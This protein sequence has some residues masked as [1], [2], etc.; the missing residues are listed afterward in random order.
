MKVFLTGATG[1]VGYH[2]AC[3]LAA[4]G[5]QLRL[6]VRKASNLANLEGIAG[7]TH[8]GDLAAP[9]SLK[10]ALAGLRRRR[11]C[12]RRLPALDSRPSGH[13]PH[14]R[15]GHARV[16]APGSRSRRATLCLHLLGC[17]HALLHRRHHQRRRH[18]SLAGRHGGPLQ[19]LQVPGGAG[20][21]PGRPSRTTG[22]HSE[23]HHAPS[24]RTT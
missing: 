22:R 23:P 1:F 19:A 20:G 13:V 14:Q 21:D 5:A 12:C 2:V 6:L 17:H 8:T 4:E 3:A 24:E 16:A 7:E 11:A 18:S 10:P 15:G 9:E